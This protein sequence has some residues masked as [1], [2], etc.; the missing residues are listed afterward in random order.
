[1]AWRNIVRSLTTLGFTYS[2]VWMLVLP[3]I[4]MCHTDNIFNNLFNSLVLVHFQEFSMLRD[5][6]HT[7]LS[8]SRHISILLGAKKHRRLSNNIN[9]FLAFEKYYMN[10]WLFEIFNI[11]GKK[12]YENKP[13]VRPVSWWLAYY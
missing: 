3:I 4:C 7:I 11:H 10:H 13:P 9:I 2:A 1:M 8:T 5:I 6:F 12:S